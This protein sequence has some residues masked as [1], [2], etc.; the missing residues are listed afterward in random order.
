MTASLPTI[1][2]T[3]TEPALDTST[4]STAPPAPHPGSPPLPAVGRPSTAELI[5]LLPGLVGDP[6]GVLQ[7][8][9]DRHGPLVLLE[10]GP[11]TALVVAE[12]EAIREV[13]VERQHDLVKGA[14]VRSTKVLLGEGLLTSEGELHAR[15]R[16]LVS[17]AFHRPRLVRYATT[18]AEVAADEAAGWADG[19]VIEG[20]AAMARLALRIVGRTLF[21]LDLSTEA[22]EVGDALQRVLA[23][24]NRQLP[25]AQ[26]I[27]QGLTPDEEAEATELVARLDRVLADVIDER[28]QRGGEDDLVSILLRERDVADGGDGG[29]LTDGEVRDEAM[30]L[31]LAG[32]ETTANALSWA[33][34]LLAAHPE[35]QAAVAQEV[36]A[37]PAGRPVGVDDLP[38]LAHTRAVLDETLRLFPP[39]WITT[40]EVATPTRIAGVDLPAGA[41]VLVS[42]LL[43]H[44]DP[45]WWE[46]P[47]SFQPARWLTPDP[48]RPKWA[49]VPFGGGA[50]SCVGEHFARM[51]ATIALAEIVR[52]WRLEPAGAAPSPQ[53]LVTMRPSAV[54][55]RLH[56]R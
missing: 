43:V 42:P 21:G 40:R 23:M 45:R 14:A 37:I 34:H 36:A 27:G 18:M 26:A 22:S 10:I 47:E 19:E 11:M 52:R 55:L 41:Q 9:R 6:V 16:R 46:Q 28:R 3:P 2:R 53:A 35:V 20:H 31:L 12:P 44:H 49:F 38:E 32:H 39:A 54:P 17:P 51:E 8:L 15:R 48:D 25:I 50:R 29:G 13:L 56:A 33:L 1:T 7:A 24:A 30:E 4:A 5:E